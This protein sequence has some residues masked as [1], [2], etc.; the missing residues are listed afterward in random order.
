MSSTQNE[1]KQNH[2]DR[3]KVE[4][5]KNIFQAEMAILDGDYENAVKVL[6]SCDEIERALNIFVDLGLLSEAKNYAIPKT[7][8]LMI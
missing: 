5:I 6:V 1:L 4:R 2:N 3:S 8:V 7:L